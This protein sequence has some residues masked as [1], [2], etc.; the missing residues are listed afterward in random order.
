VLGGVRDDLR[1][2]RKDQRYLA[3]IESA[4]GMATVKAAW[5]YC[6]D[7][8]EDAALALSASTGAPLEADLEAKL[9]HGA[10]AEFPLGGDDL[11]A[12][13]PA[14]KAVGRALRR[15]EEAW[16]AS[17]FA[18]SKADLLKELGFD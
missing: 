16:V 14:G 6:R 7:V 15:A 8:A 2:S 1:L 12:H 4:L 3:D 18:A 13:M 5:R 9:D 11:L 10:S 17:G